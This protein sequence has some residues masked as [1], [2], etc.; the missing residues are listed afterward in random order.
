MAALDNSMHNSQDDQK[1]EHEQA[2]QHLSDQLIQLE[3]G[4]SLSSILDYLYKVIAYSLNWHT[5]S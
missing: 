2:F 3:L 4:G 1:Q 5:I